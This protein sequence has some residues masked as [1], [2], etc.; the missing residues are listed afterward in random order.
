MGDPPGGVTDLVVDAGLL[1]NRAAEARR[2]Y[3]WK[4]IKKYFWEQ[5][6][7]AVWKIFK[8]ISICCAVEQQLQA[9]LTIGENASNSVF[10]I[11]DNKILLL[12]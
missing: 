7:S 10:E 9:Q 12:F 2:G 5:N 1:L 6:T 8:I 4:Y 11:Y 3:A